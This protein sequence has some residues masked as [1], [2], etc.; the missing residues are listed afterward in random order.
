MIATHLG[1]DSLKPG[2]AASLTAADLEA[3]LSSGSLGLN[4]TQVESVRAASSFERK[5]ARMAAAVRSSQFMGRYNSDLV[6]R[7]ARQAELT[8]HWYAKGMLEPDLRSEL[9]GIQTCVKH[10]GHCKLHALRHITALQPVLATD[11]ER[12]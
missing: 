2:G 4:D 3:A 9:R 1:R 10:H 11:A 5:A 8:R 12:R 6:G 7:E